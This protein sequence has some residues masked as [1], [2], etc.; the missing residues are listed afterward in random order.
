VGQVSA[1]SLPTLWDPQDLFFHLLVY[2]G[3]P[4]AVVA[5]ATALLA[6]YKA[7]MGW[8]GFGKTTV[9]MGTVASGKVKAWTSEQLRALVALGAF[10]VVTVCFSYMLAVIGYAAT[11]MIEADPQHVFTPGQLADHVSIALWP[12]VA[13]WIVVGESACVLIL[14]LASIGEATGLRKLAKFAGGLVWVAAW[15][16]AFWL[17]VSGICMCLGLLLETGSPP[18]SNDV[19][20][21]LLWDAGITAAIALVVA[22]SVPRVARASARAFGHPHSP[23][24]P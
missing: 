17:G 4:A 23:R 2:A 1:G 19:P 21:P 5:V 10:S 14:G 15:I 24:R 11:L 18:S 20:V 12:P 8:I 13:V 7:V 9:R 22:L 16:I 6:S 3:V